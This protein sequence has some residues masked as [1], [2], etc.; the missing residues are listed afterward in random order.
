MGLESKSKSNK[1]WGWFDNVQQ[2]GDSAD[3]LLP[4]P[5]LDLT[6]MYARVFSTPDGEKVLAHLQSLTFSRG[7]SPGAKNSLLRHVEGQRQLVAYVMAL[8]RRGRGQ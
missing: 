3:N 7:I 5:G 4:E 2:K 6:R 1:G 8:C